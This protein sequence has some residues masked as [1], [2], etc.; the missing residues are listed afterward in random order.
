MRLFFLPLKDGEKHIFFATE[1]NCINIFK[2]VTKY[3]II[4]IW[5]KLGGFF[6][7]HIFGF[8]GG[9]LFLNTENVTFFVMF[10]DANVACIYITPFSEN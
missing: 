4:N 8:Y 9:G 7:D 5:G 10:V 6:W 1:F 2:K 3:A